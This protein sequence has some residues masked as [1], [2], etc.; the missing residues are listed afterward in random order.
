M[1]GSISSRFND[2]KILLEIVFLTLKLAIGCYCSNHY[3]GREFLPKEKR[4]LESCKSFGQ[5]L[6]P[7]RCFS[8]DLLQK[9]FVKSPDKCP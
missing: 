1:N 7:K 3:G 4:S 5:N 9:F 8:G 6:Y 2:R